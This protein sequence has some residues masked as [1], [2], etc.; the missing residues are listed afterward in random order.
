MANAFGGN[1][2]SSLENMLRMGGERADAGVGAA[3]NGLSAVLAG[4]VTARKYWLGF[5][6]CQ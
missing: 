5:D 2:N 6:T 4:G 3:S 1:P